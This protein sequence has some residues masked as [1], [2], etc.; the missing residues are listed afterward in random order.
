MN[1]NE[2]SLFFLFLIPAGFLIAALRERSN[3]KQR[4]ALG[5]LAVLT[6]VAITPF[7]IF[8]EK[9]GS[10]VTTVNSLLT[11]TSQTEV[12]DNRPIL[13]EVYSDY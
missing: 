11:Q 7:V 10:D 5:L 9:K 12:S 1:L 2:Y 13:L 4:Q 3:P 8:P 6:F